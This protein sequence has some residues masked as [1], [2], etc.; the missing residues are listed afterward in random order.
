MMIEVVVHHLE[1]GGHGAVG[2]LAAAY[3]RDHA[4]ED[5]G[6]CQQLR[7]GQLRAVAGYL[8]R[9]VAGSRGLFASQVSCDKQRKNSNGVSRLMRQGVFK[10]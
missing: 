9:Y 8:Q 3:L 5:G 6:S 4:S 7:V 1:G 2:K 10:G